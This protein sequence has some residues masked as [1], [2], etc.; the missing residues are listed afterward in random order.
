MVDVTAKDVTW[1]VAVARGVVSMRA[2][3][4]AA[5]AEGQ[6]PKGDVL[7]VARIA[8]I[9]AA[10]KTSELIPMWPP[11]QHQ[12]RGG[13][14]HPPRNTPVRRDR[15]HRPDRRPDRCRDG[16]AHRGVRG[17]PHHLRHVQGG[18]PGNDRGRDP[19]RAQERAARAAPST[20]SSPIIDP[21]F[22]SFSGKP[23]K[24]LAQAPKYTPKRQAARRTHVRP[25]L[26]ACIRAFA[27]TEPAASV[28]LDCDGTNQSMADGGPSAGEASR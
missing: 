24:F 16:G 18:G 2:E 11:S 8:G 7:A 23:L 22:A 17:G 25:W 19:P 20:G 15:G 21:G 27:G 14:A 1:R 3:T 10:K 13:P 5:I 12:R 26:C 6:I 9:M 28:A 4:L